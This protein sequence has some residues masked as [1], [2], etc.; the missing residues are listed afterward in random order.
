MADSDKLSSALQRLL[1]DEHLPSSMLA[2][3]A[4][5]HEPIARHIAKRAA[6]S[7]HPFIVGLCGPQGSGKSTLAVV[8]RTILAAHGAAVASI[9][10]D[11]FYLTRLEREHLASRVHPLLQTRGVPGTHDVALAMTTLD[12]LSRHGTVALPSFDKAADDRRPERLWPQVQT[13]LDILIFEGWC[14]GATAQENAALRD[15]INALE[16]EYDAHRTWRTYVNE[17]LQNEYR[18]LFARLDLMIALT[19]STFDTVYEWRAEQERKLRERVERRGDDASRLMT[20]RELRR[21]IAH[22]ER[23]TSHIMSTMPIDADI[24]LALDSSRRI[25]EVSSL[26]LEQGPR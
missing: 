12:A 23:L 6:E 3:I 25:L 4:R 2:T 15:P 5:V 17:R 1:A 9:S 21:F 13:P 19:T 20:E 16:R 8:L 11:D 24:V 18:I 10:I 26:S 7:K 22:Y 14:V